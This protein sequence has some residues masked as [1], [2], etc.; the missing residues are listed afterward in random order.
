M[1]SIAAIMSRSQALEM[2][3][4]LYDMW[5]GLDG[6]TL[7]QIC[8]KTN[9]ID[10]IEIC[11]QKLIDGQGSLNWQTLCQI[12]QSYETDN[13][14]EV[15]TSCQVTEAEFNTQGQDMLPIKGKIKLRYYES[16][17]RAV[18]PDMIEDMADRDV[19]YEEQNKIVI[20]KLQCKVP[21]VLGSRQCIAM[22]NEL[23]EGQESNLQHPLTSMYLDA[24]WDK[25]RKVVLVYSTINILQFIFLALTIIFDPYSEE[26]MAINSIWSLVMLLLELRQLAKKGS[27]YLRDPYN[28][29]DN[30]GNI[31]V[32]VMYFKLKAFG[33]HTYE[34]DLRKTLMI[35][36]LLTLGLRA[37]SQL[38]MF[39]KFR[40]LIHLITE[41]FGDMYY[42]GSVIALI[43]FL[44][45]VC[46]SSS[47]IVYIDKYD[48]QHS[49]YE[50]I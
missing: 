47:R 44:M 21:M 38:R 29:L 15:L 3:S 43:I 20:S 9:D 14:Q 37:V 33:S 28:Y 5:M 30:I 23:T 36:G 25:Y 17:N 35:C 22:L 4:D 18:N 46:S 10:S 45:S 2:A 41:T 6:Q 26:M 31:S 19:E 13:V 1:F 48:D 7:I 49:N 12:I 39:N 27:S 32:I 8:G 34:S 40:V 24:L 50:I 16:Q 42:F 11:L